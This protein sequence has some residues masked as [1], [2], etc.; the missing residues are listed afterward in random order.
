MLTS[1]MASTQHLWGHLLSYDWHLLCSSGSPFIQQICSS[2]VAFV[3]CAQH[4][5][6]DICISVCGIVL[7]TRRSTTATS[8][9]LWNIMSTHGNTHR[10]WHARYHPNALSSCNQAFKHSKRFACRNQPR[11]NIIKLA[12][13]P[14]HENVYATLLKNVGG[15]VRKLV[16]PLSYSD[17]LVYNHKIELTYTCTVAYTEKCF[18]KSFITNRQ[19]WTHAGF[20]ACALAWTNAISNT[21]L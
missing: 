15:L 17:A 11:L 14:T 12:S 16:C 18:N 10:R 1:V 19:S 5:S 7:E 2:R 6:G 8:E 13:T 3:A 4:L 20:D 9:E 21:H